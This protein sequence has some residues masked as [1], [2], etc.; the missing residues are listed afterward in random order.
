MSEDT[1]ARIIKLINKG[2]RVSLANDAVLH[3]ADAMTAS[4]LSQL[5]EVIE[6]I[7][8]GQL[9]DEVQSR[10]LRIKNDARGCA[11]AFEDWSKN[12][13]E[14]SEQIGNE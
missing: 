4:L 8:K 3:R 14:R 1:D 2:R 12:N 6:D 10:L 11:H 9:P 7:H 13:F 5:C